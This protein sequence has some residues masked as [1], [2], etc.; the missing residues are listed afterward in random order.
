MSDRLTKKL[1]TLKHIPLELFCENVKSVGL[2]QKRWVAQQGDSCLLSQMQFLSLVSFFTDDKPLGNLVK[3][4]KQTLDN[5]YFLTDADINR[6]SKLSPERVPSFLDNLRQEILSDSVR[7]NESNSTLATIYRRYGG[8]LNP[9][10]DNPTNFMCREV[11][12]LM[13]PSLRGWS[14]V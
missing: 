4:Y 9:P 3:K 8:L 2:G 6:A 14:L 11:V 7:I 5:V 13:G 1:S 10:P 12:K